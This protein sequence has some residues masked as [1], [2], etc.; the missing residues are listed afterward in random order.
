MGLINM[1]ENFTARTGASGKLENERKQEIVTSFLVD[2]PE[3][4][5]K[6]CHDGGSNF[7]CGHKVF[8]DGG[9]GEKISPDRKEAGNNEPD[10][11][12]PCARYD[13]WSLSKGARPK[14]EDRN[15][16]FP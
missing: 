9:T 3:I 8:D 10:Y 2:I 4:K 6:V 16:R 12:F 7:A 15:T 11:A 1:V 5:I 13:N 14:T